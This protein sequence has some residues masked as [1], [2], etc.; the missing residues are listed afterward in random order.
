N[1]NEPPANPSFIL[2][3]ILQSSKYISPTGV[4]NAVNL[5]HVIFKEASVSPSANN[6]ENVSSPFSF[7]PPLDNKALD[8]Q[9]PVSSALT[10]ILRDVYLEQ[11]DW[12]KELGLV[13]LI[14]IYRNMDPQGNDL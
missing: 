14:S 2:T 4:L 5:L 11:I 10:H 12:Q 3:C 9:K 13:N 7:L 8:P 6:T 1:A